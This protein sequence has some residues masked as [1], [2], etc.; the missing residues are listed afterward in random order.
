MRRRLESGP[1]GLQRW[2][3][4]MSDSCRSSRARSVWRNSHPLKNGAFHG[5]PDKQ[6]FA[7]FMQTHRPARQRTGGLHGVRGASDRKPP[8][9]FLAHQ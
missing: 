2:A 1:G 3:P 9:R 7:N 4:D 5:A 6:H 8:H